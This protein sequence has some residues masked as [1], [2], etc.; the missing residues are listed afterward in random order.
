MKWL[1]FPCF[2]L[3]LLGLVSANYLPVIIWGPHVRHESAV[4]LKSHYGYEFIDILSKHSTVDTITFIVVEDQLSVE[5]LSHCKA[6][7]GQTCFKGMQSIETKLYLPSVEYPAYAIQDR[8][9]EE[10]DM[11]EID[12]Q[13]RGNFSESL[14]KRTGNF[15][16]VNFGDDNYTNETISEK[17]TRHDQMITSFYKEFL[18]QNGRRVVVVFTGKRGVNLLRFLREASPFTY[19]EA[20]NSTDSTNSTNSTTHVGY[21]WKTE[22]VLLYYTSIDL[23][24]SNKSTSMNV[25]NV[26]VQATNGT[27]TTE[28]IDDVQEIPQA[29]FST[30]NEANNGTNTTVV[31]TA[32][33]LIIT[34]T[35]DDVDIFKFVITTDNGYWSANQFTWNDVPLV[36]SRLISAASGFSYHC[37]P[38]ITLTSQNGTAIGQ[39]ETETD[40]YG[41]ETDGQDETEAERN[42]TEIVISW[43]GLQLQPKFDYVEGIKLTTFSDAYDCV[44]FVSTGIL[45]G[46]FVVFLLVFILFIGILCIMDIKPIDRFEDPKGPQITFTVND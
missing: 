19:F 31:H 34:I 3:H 10:A 20:E 14:K 46:L 35:V 17:L 24:I 26:T 18:S 23:E 45:S 9:L 13:S 30:E 12:L 44:G 39:N 29:D 21:V 1:I 15:V 6:P 36:P 38:T 25:T 28:A 33:H 8:A 40:Q 43:I 22:T 27:N 16:F 41:S 37:T 5:D 2:V 42:R 11:F 4:A 32:T 7:N